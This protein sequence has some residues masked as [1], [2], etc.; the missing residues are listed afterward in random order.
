MN[1]PTNFSAAT[2]MLLFQTWIFNYFA[3]VLPFCRFVVML[4]CCFAVLSFCRLAV[5]LFCDNVETADLI[6]RGTVLSQG[7]KLDLSDVSFRW[8]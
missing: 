3:A 8:H 1:I 5:L 2:R 7:L 6:Y 4:S